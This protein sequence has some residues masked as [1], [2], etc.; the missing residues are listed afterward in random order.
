MSHTPP[1]TSQMNNP[2]TNILQQGHIAQDWFGAS[3]PENHFS[4]SISGNNVGFET[5]VK[6]SPPSTFP[7]KSG[8]Y[9]EGLWEYDV[10][11]LFIA[12]DKGERY[13]E[14][15]LAPNGAWWLM[16]FS[17]PRQRLADLRI[18][19]HDIKTE[20]TLT[21][22]AWKASL[23]IPLGLLQNILQTDNMR[24]NVTYI[25]GEPR[26]HLSY[27]KLQSAKP[28]FHIPERFKNLSP[29]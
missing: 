8:E 14:I 20:S 6:A 12:A 22:Q 3:C 13:I 21:K 18:D 28:D 16:T 27:C 24:F 29:N 9:F 7:A 23:C 17:A 26:Q 2:N 19:L 25:L 1:N 4:L 5:E 11:E 15:N 10:A